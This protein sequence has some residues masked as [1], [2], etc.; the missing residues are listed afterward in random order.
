MSY[1]DAYNAAKKA[2]RESRLAALRDGRK[3]RSHKFAPK[4]GAGSY[5][6]KPKNNKERH[7][8]H[9]H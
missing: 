3:T 5:K 2:E 8:H 7:D 9:D 1:E 4:K 6:R